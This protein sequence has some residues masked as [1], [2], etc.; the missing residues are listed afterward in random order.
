MLLL[1]QLLNKRST[2]KVLLTTVEEQHAR[3]ACVSLRISHSETWIANLPVLTTPIRQPTAWR[4]QTWLVTWLCAIKTKVFIQ[5]YIFV[6]GYNSDYFQLFL[7]GFKRRFMQIAGL[8]SE[9]LHTSVT[10]QFFHFF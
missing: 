1:V 9:P 6:L 8:H 2:T 4:Y 7:R 3:G 10:I 5:V